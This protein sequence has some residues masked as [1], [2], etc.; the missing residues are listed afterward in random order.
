MTV[1]LITRWNFCL[2]CRDAG[3][4]R[5]FFVNSGY[6]GCDVDNGWFTVT[7]GNVGAQ[8]PWEAGTDAEKP[9]FLYSKGT[10]K[11]QNN[12]GYPYVMKSLL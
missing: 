5:R 6:G 12:S 4:V 8:C 3:I 11:S 1:I 2:F 10:T 9:M 7:D